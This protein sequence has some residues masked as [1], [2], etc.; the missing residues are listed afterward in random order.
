MSMENGGSDI[1]RGIIRLG[2]LNKPIRIRRT[3]NKPILPL[4]ISVPQFPMFSSFFYPE[5]GGS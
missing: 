1:Q 3:R 2:T 4:C 5:D